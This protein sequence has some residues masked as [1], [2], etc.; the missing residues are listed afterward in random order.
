MK[1]RFGNLN[2]LARDFATADA[3]AEHPAH[4]T[5]ALIGAAFGVLRK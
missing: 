5:V 1:S 3:S 2:L 4:T